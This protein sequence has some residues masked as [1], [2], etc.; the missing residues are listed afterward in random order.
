MA[1]LA[2]GIGLILMINSGVGLER[3]HTSPPDVSSMELWIVKFM[4]A[5]IALLGICFIVFGLYLGRANKSKE[6]DD[7]NG[8][9]P[10]C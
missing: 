3:L 4:V 6:A 5:V 9:S 10:G 1:M 8:I 2:W 7:G